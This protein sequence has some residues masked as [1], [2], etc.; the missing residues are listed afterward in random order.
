[1]PKSPDLPKLPANLKFEAALAELETL[2]DTLEGGDLELEASIAA[3]QRGMA[4]LRHCRAQLQAAGQ[5]IQ[6]LGPA[7]G[8]ADGNFL[9]VRAGSGDP[10]APRDLE[11]ADV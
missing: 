11:D 3:Y 4:L 5:K 1:M 8:T 9:P 7:D 6:T 10:P 2:V